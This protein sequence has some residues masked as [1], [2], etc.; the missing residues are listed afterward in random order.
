[1]SELPQLSPR[2]SR[3]ELRKAVLRLRLEVQRQQLRQESEKLLQPL[4]QARDLGQ[5]VR[6]QFSGGASLWAAGGAAA[7]AALMLRRKRGLVRL[8]RLAV[9]L[10]PLLLKLRKT[11]DK[12]T[13]PTAD[14]GG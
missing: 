11:A 14:Q 6:Q 7:A 2:P 12:P 10:A 8:L 3:R 4:R 13:K 9:V 1:M 5:G